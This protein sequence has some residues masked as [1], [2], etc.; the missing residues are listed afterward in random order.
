MKA[1]PNQHIKLTGQAP[2]K[3]IGA[4]CGYFTSRQK[5]AGLVVG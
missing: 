3:S 1:L 4:S 5:A 2:I